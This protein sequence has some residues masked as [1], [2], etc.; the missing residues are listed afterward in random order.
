MGIVAYRLV[1][2]S[3]LSGV[4][5]VF[6]VSM[7]RN[8]TL[9]L[10]HV[11]DWGVITVDT[12]GTFEVGPVCIMDSWDQVLQRKTVRLLKVMCQHRGVEE[13]TW[14]HEDTM[15]ATYPFLFWDEGMWFSHLILKWLVYMHEIVYIKYACELIR[16]C[17]EFWDEILLRRG[18]GGGGGE[19]CKT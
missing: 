9:N 4:H 13:A 10:T 17:V 3:S 11:A 8:Y 14:E 19:E 16:M 1:L 18:G 2:P 15:Q 6:H 5:E 7:L 12:Y